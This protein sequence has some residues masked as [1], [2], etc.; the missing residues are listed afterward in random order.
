MSTR[1]ITCQML[2]DEIR[3]AMERTGCTHEVVWL[4]RQLH[5]VP[6]H[7]CEEVQQQIE[8][9]QDADT[10]L[11]AMAQ[12]GNSFIGLESRHAT[13]VLP[14]FADCLHVISSLQQGDVGALD[15]RT[16]Y[17][18][19]GWLQGE[20]A[21]HNEYKRFAAQRGEEKAQKAYRR[22]LA[23]YRQVTMVETGAYNLAQC[24]GEARETAELLGLAYGTAPGSIR[25]LEKLFAGQWD[26]EFMVLAPGKAF[27]AQDFFA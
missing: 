22:M 7:L 20:K 9:A 21:L 8:K 23:Q 16:L 12:C 13:L 2:E 17:L 27:A 14:R 18:T 10:I 5:S 19:H 15:P 3:L 25:V 6:K 26:E 11:L 4:E 24:E 1:I